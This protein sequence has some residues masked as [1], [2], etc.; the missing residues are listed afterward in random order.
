MVA[1]VNPPQQPGSLWSS[2]GA[3][4]A[5]RTRQLVVLSGLIHSCL[6]FEAARS[7]DLRPQAWQGPPTHTTCFHFRPHHHPP[8]TTYF[9]V[10]G[11]CI[12]QASMYMQHNRDVEIHGI[13]LIFH[14]KSILSTFYG[15]YARL[16]PSSLTHLET[17]TGLTPIQKSGAA[18]GEKHK[19]KRKL[20]RK[21]KEKK[22]NTRFSSLLPTC[23]LQ[24][25]HVYRKPQFSRRSHFKMS[26][27]S[28]SGEPRLD[29]ALPSS[30]P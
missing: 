13:A 16:P 19:R 3:A 2:A 11:V 10:Y 18:A 17:P 8:T 12:V 22:S 20:K 6:I 23:S 1:C 24:D 25:S 14:L 5:R 9:V 30:T 27:A 29:I 21:R 28:G 15:L 7:G 4:Q 26:L